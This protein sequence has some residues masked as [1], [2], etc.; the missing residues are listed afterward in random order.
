[1]SLVP[2]LIFGPILAWLILLTWA[3][4]RAASEADEIEAES[5]NEIEV[6]RQSWPHENVLVMAVTSDA[7]GDRQ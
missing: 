7:K 3:A 2:V 1:M 5:L 4:C 6:Q